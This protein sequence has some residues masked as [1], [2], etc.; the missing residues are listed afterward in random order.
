MPNIYFFTGFPG[1]LASALIRKMI[2]DGRNAGHFYLLVLPELA[3]KAQREAKKIAID[4]SVSTDAFTVLS[5]DITKPDLG[6]PDETHSEL[7]QSV[8]H[9]FH[10]AAIY[11]L[12][13]PKD[14]AYN[15]NVNGT[16]NVNE[17]VLSL[18]N[19][20]RYIYFSTAYVSGTREGRIYEKELEMGQAFKNHYEQT[21]YEA[22]VL[23]NKIMD[24][25][26]TTIIR[27]GVVRGDSQTGETI[28]F[29]GP[30]M[31]LNMF[32]ALRFLP[33]I[34]YMGNGEAPGNFVP[35]DYVLKATVYLGHEEVGAGKTY[36]LADP[37]PYRMKEVYYML[38]KE[39]LAKEPAGMIPLPVAKGFMS[40]SAI[41]KWLRVEKEGLDYFTCK[42]EHDCSQAQKDLQGSG[43]TCPDFRETVKPMVDFY[44]KHKMDQEKHIRIR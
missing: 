3:E 8:T 12:A 26:P 29:D 1:F 32:E 43:I 28:K 44:K 25:V 18:E 21:K 15:V 23:V 13:V 22:E 40:L 41:R 14:I 38:M 27:P 4:E 5:G 37:N 19:L 31:I 30:Y 20:Q 36:H 42:A 16:R 2:R 17:W 24:R 10:L 7:R 35:S 39:Y 9:V 34:P 6:L 11:D 33:F